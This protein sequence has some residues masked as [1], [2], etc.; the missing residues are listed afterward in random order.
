VAAP[1]LRFTAR[2]LDAPPPPRD[3]LLSR[4]CADVGDV[5][6]ISEAW[7]V[8]QLVTP[9]GGQ[10]HEEA[11]LAIA[12]DTESEPEPRELAPFIARLS[13]QRSVRELGVHRWIHVNDA[14][15]AKVE[16]HGL[17]VYTQSTPPPRHIGAY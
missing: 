7:L 13:Q 12:F 14:I 5:P 6:E 3:D 10:A 4:L 8:R 15:R 11:A 2:W 17:R 9:E 1:P 16:R